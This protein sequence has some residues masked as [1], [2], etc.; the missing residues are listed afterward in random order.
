MHMGFFP[1]YFKYTVPIQ[2]DETQAPLPYKL[3]T[4]DGNFIRNAG[5]AISLFITFLV[6]WT[7]LCLCV[8]LINKILRKSDIW[9]QG[10]AKNSLIAAT[11]LLSMVVFFF[12]V[13][14]LLYDDVY[15]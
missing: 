13:S 4:L 11:E 9:Y 5:Y 1:N 14:Q 8:Y 10:I 15:P 12:S 7:V 3:A 2:Y 6:A